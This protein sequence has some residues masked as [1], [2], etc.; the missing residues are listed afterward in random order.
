[1]FKFGVGPLQCL[2]RDQ[3]RQLYTRAQQLQRHPHVDPPRPAVLN[4]ELSQLR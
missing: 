3:G 2:R 4:V 1:L